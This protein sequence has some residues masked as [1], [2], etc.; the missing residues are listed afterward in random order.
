VE[1][2]EAGANR[3]C[4]PASAEAVAEAICRGMADGFPAAAW[5]SL[6]G[7]GHAAERVAAA[8]CELVYGEEGRCE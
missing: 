5:R 2:V 3:L 4:P 6:Y 7:D 1:L 8:V